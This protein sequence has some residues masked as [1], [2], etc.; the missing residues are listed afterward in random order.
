MQYFVE[1]LFIYFNNYNDERH[2][3][4]I[5]EIISLNISQCEAILDPNQTM[6]LREYVLLCLSVVLLE[7]GL[8]L[9][10][11]PKPSI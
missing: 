10:F 6:P 5:N 9:A 3:L 1:I 11:I 7:L 8:G 2:F 4:Q